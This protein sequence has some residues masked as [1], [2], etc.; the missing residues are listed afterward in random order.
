MHFNHQTKSLHYFS[1]LAVQDRIPTDNL[2]DV[3]SG[4]PTLELQDFL[5]SNDDYVKIKSHFISRILCSNMDFFHKVF[6]TSITHHIPHR[7]SAEMSQVSKV[8]S[9]LYGLLHVSN[10]SAGLC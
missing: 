8:V 6:E 9:L 1:V 3:H 4:H 10:L 7:Y 5:P 2:L